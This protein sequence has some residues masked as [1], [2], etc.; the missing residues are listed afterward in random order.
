MAEDTCQEF[1]QAQKDIPG[2]PEPGSQLPL[3]VYFLIYNLNSLDIRFS[4]LRN[5][6]YHEEPEVYEGIFQE[7]NNLRAY[8][9]WF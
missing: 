5:P 4:L 7:S 9:Y 1:N 6:F 8:L 2:N 3:F